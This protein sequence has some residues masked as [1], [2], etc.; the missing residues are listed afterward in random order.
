MPA[1]PTSRWSPQDEEVLHQWDRKCRQSCHTVIYPGLTGQILRQQ[2]IQGDSCITFTSVYPD[3][4][5]S[6]HFISHRDQL[7]VHGEQIIE[8]F[9]IHT[10]LYNALRKRFMVAGKHARRVAPHPVFFRL[11]RLTESQERCQFN[12]GFSGRFHPI[13]Y[14]VSVSVY[15]FSDTLM[16]II[17]QK[18]GKLKTLSLLSQ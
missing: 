8:H 14:S 17:A 3:F 12:S 18:H 2:M 7:A 5:L 10:R 16:L 13:Y 15:D 4:T 1:R 11:K 9:R 6:F